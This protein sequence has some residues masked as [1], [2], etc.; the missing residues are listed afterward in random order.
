MLKTG[1]R[2]VPSSNSGHACRLSRS[3]FSVVFSESCVNRG[4]DPLERPSTEGTPPIDPG[5]TSGQLSLNLQPNQP[6]FSFM[7]NCTFIWR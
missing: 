3:E 2:E 1:R 4:Y 6:K 7:Q 5:L